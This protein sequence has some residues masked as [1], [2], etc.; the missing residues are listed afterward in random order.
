MTA[1]QY[2]HSAER[3]SDTPTAPPVLTDAAVGVTTAVVV[4]SVATAPIAA[5]AA[6]GGLAGLGAVSV[7]RRMGVPVDRVAA[8]ALRRSVR[9][10][11]TS[12]R[13][14]R[15]FGTRAAGMSRSA[16]GDARASASDVWAKFQ[17]SLQSPESDAAASGDDGS[18]VAEPSTV[19]GEPD[20]LT[21]DT[22][23]FHCTVTDDR[24]GDERMDNDDECC[25][26]TLDPCDDMCARLGIEKE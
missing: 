1:P 4:A 12:L 14:S 23:C 25:A 8:T 15:R 7:A 16:L 6:V 11:E 2:E 5:A 17:D 20:P 10:T 9:A 13:A 26:C 18:C 24:V 19:K 3:E 21:H 22:C